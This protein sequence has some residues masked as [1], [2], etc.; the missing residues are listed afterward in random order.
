M[1][2]MTFTVDEETARRLREA[3]ERLRKPKS[4]VVREAIRDYADRIGKL[5]EEERRHML[6]VIDRVMHRIPRRSPAEV[7]AEIAEIR[8][9]RRRGGRGHP[10]E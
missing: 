2:K 4:Q 8:S 5:S 9:A 6:A 3:A 1:V 7:E 10:V